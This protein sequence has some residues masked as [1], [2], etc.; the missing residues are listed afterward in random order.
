M[1]ARPD[2]SLPPSPR[3]MNDDPYRVAR[4]A[5][6]LR[7]GARIRL[8][9]RRQQLVERLDALDTVVASWMRERREALDEAEEIHDSLWPTVEAGWGRRPPRP[10]R[11]PMAPQVVDP[12]PV[13]GAALRSLCCALLHR[14]G[15]LALVELHTLIHVYGY[16]IFSRTPV[17]TLADSLGYETL[18]GRAERVRRGVYRA[19][20]PAPPA[21]DPRLAGAPESWFPA[22][23]AWQRGGPFSDG[24]DDGLAGE[25]DGLGVVDRGAWDSGGVDGRETL[26]AA[27]VDALGIGPVEGQ[28]GEELGRHAPALAGV[29]AP[30]ARTGAGGVAAPAANGRA[31]SPATRR[32]NRPDRGRCRP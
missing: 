1:H 21:I 7:C 16:E 28:T 29:V 19:R 24:G 26:E 18:E 11:S 30:T 8:D 23:A 14:H 12:Y 15:E 2:G 4:R 10:G 31:R 6:G 5:A 20:G 17:K 32:R 25:P 3:W 13:R 9:Q 27:T 22:F